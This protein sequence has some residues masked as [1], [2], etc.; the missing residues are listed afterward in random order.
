MDDRDT[1][2]DR[3]CNVR[4][5]VRYPVL[6]DDCDAVTRNISQSGVYIETDHPLDIGQHIS[7]AVLFPHKAVVRSNAWCKGRVVRVDVRETG[8][9]GVGVD[10]DHDHQ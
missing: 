10:F 8:Q 2:A 1:T 5:M 6:L 9:V 7:F 3:R 4:H